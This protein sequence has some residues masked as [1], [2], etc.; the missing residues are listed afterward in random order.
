MG[1]TGTQ[2]MFFQ[3]TRATTN[4][5]ADCES[6]YSNNAWQCVATTYDETDG[7]RIFVG[8]L[9]S[10]L[11]EVSY[12]TAPT[13]GSGATNADNTETLKIFNRTTLVGAPA[14]RAGNFMFWNRRL[15]LGELRT[16]QWRP[17][18]S[19]GLVVWHNYNEGTGTQ[20]DYSGAKNTGTV[21]G[22]TY[23]S[24]NVPLGVLFGGDTQNEP[25]VP[26]TI[27]SLS[28]TD[29]EIVTEV[30]APALSNASS[31]I[32]PL[33]VEMAF[34]VENGQLSNPGSPG[35]VLSPLDVEIAFE[36]EPGVLS[37]ASGQTISAQD[38]EIIAEIDSGVLSNSSSTPNLVPLDVELGF[39]AGGASISLPV[40]GGARFVLVRRRRRR[41]LK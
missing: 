39:Q 13:V 3:I 17:H 12:A 40:S 7:P 10:A 26:S 14:G 41:R 8:S 20:R 16:H 5:L 31:P 2:G 11:A 1:F 21:T 4:A 23:L 36:V 29:V 19:S 37:N 38:V 15:T 28:A 9:T 34:E 6:A 18:A 35:G 33:D 24:S 25:V 27:P 32:S 22:A 30:E